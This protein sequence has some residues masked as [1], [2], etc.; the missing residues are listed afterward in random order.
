[1]TQEGDVTLTQ[2]EMSDTVRLLQIAAN[3]FRDLGFIEGSMAFES[4]VKVLK[5]KQHGTF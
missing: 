2:E 3:I 4:Q 1:M 5:E